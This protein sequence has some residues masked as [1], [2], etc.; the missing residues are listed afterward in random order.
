MTTCPSHH[1]T[2]HSRTGKLRQRWSL[3]RSCWG[4]AGMSVLDRW[5]MNCG[6]ATSCNTVTPLDEM[7]A[8]QPRSSLEDRSGTLYRPINAA[9]LQSG[10]GRQGSLKLRLPGNS[11]RWR[12]TTIGGHATFRCRPR[13]AMSPCKTI[14]W[15]GDHL[16]TVPKGPLWDYRRSGTS[17][18]VFSTSGGRLGPCAI[19]VA[20]LTASSHIICNHTLLISWQDES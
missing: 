7:A 14:G 1:P 4:D 19:Q 13:E 11:R 3:W 9:L 2:T 18:S 17:R 6:T 20:S 12:M 8:S 15:E 16:I 5:T 10:S